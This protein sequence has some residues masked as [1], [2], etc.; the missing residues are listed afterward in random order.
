MA[1]IV[2]SVFSRSTLIST[3]LNGRQH[4]LFL[5]IGTIGRKQAIFPIHY[6][7]NQRRPTACQLS[8]WLPFSCGGKASFWQSFRSCLTDLTQNKSTVNGSSVSSQTA[9]KDASASLSKA[10]SAGK[11]KRPKTDFSQTY[12]ANIHIPESRAMNEYLLES[13]ELDSLPSFPRR[14]PYPEKEK[15]TVYRRRDLEQRAITKWGSLENLQL[16]KDF[17]KAREQRRQKY[18]TLKGNEE[19]EG[20]EQEQ[21]KPTNEQPN[22]FSPVLPKS[23]GPSQNMFQHGSGRVVLYAIAINAANCVMKCV[24]WL[25]TGSHSMFSEFI[26]SLADTAN[27][28]ILAAG[29][30]QSLKQPDLEHPYGW[31]NFRNVSS[32]I[33]GVGIFC[34]GAGVSIY[35]GIVGLHNPAEVESLVWALAVLGGSFMSEGATLLVA[36]NEVRQSCRIQQMSF[37]QYVFRGRDPSVNVVLLEDAAAVVGVVI[38]A[39]CITLSHYTGSSVPD[40]VGSLLIGSLLGGVASFIIYTNTL[41]LVGK[42]IPAERKIE[43]MRELESDRMIR[44]LHDVKATDVGGRYVRFKAE[45]DFDGKEITRYY[46]EQQ[47]I[48]KMLLE[49]Q[50]MKTVEEMETFMLKHG[51]NVIDTLGSEVDRIERNLKKRHPEIRHCDLEQL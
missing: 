25:Y 27:Q 28:L 1:A 18:F 35:H 11:S 2:G 8:L 22:V 46:L 48:E 36:I 26:H 47:D 44:A 24:A 45:V 49:M 14:S 17:K 50:S 38:A 33:S 41:A 23:S 12:T 43:L 30:R 42:S 3:R 13:S 16:Q 15:I 21:V 39:S 31:A 5:R 32:L 40:A 9:P 4:L 6:L 10:Q 29:I 20:F 51:E 37:F 7:A 34:V 19:D